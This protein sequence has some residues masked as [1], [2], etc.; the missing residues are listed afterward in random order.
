MG[1]S[2][3]VKADASE[4]QENPA[5]SGNQTVLIDI[6][7]ATSVT[8]LQS[9]ILVT[10]SS[11]EWNATGNG[12][13][14]VHLD[15]LDEAIPAYSAIAKGLAFVFRQ[16]RREGLRLTIACRTGEFPPVLDD[17]L[18]SFF[19]QDNVSRWRLLPLSP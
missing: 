19:G 15:S 18:D 4:A 11:R 16:L 9:L 12:T 13:M 5:V 10:R 8:D 2:S 17:E 14:N 1:K 7:G 6:G 3:A